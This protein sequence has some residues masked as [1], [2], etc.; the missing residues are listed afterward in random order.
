MYALLVLLD[1]DGD[2]TAVSVETDDDIVLDGSSRQLIQLK[3]S[4]KDPPPLS[5]KNDGFWNTISIWAPHVSDAAT[6]QFIFVTTAEVPEDG[7]LLPLTLEPRNVDVS[8]NALEE[9]ANRVIREREH[10]R[11]AGEDLPYSARVKGCEAF[12]KM[13]PEQRHQFLSQVLIKPHSPRIT[14]IQGEVE[15]RLLNCVNKGRRPFVAEHLI[16]WWD[17]QVARALMRER[18]RLLT[19]DELIEHIQESVVEY[20]RRSLPDHY[21]Y[22]EPADWHAVLTDN[23]EQQINLIDGGDDRKRQAAVALWRASNQRAEWIHERLSSV[24]QLQKFDLAL[25]ELWAERHGPMQHDTEGSSPE[26][27]CAAGRD[28]FDWAQRKSWRDA[29]SE[30][31][32]RYFVQGTYQA[33]ADTLTVGWHPN[34]LARM[35]GR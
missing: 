9:E 24:G 27:Q 16:E 5:I 18:S 10:A 13:C 7:A 35:E 22:S 8:L 32:K 1:A 3:H 19:K 11:L 14:E 34:Y 23:I 6:T 31:G 4:M 28:L 25:V 12:L 30:F 29:P 26:E 33:L 15:Q 2:D 21:S 20:G 17:N